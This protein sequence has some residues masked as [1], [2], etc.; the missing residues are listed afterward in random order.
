[1]SL[2]I[3]SL[4]RSARWRKLPASDAQKRFV[5]KR[6]K[7]RSSMGAQKFGD[8]TEAV[9]PPVS[10][11]AE[12]T[13][14]EAANIINRLKHGAKVRPASFYSLNTAQAFVLTLPLAYQP[15][16]RQIMTKNFRG[17]QGTKKGGRRTEGDEKVL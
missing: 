10:P 15:C 11:F 8:V 3:F 4:L 7:E 13:K 5:E 14:G 16:P 12:L 6:W 9:S 17:S 1:M 2:N